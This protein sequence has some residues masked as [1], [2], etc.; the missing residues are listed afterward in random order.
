M[1]IYKQFFE[2]PFIRHTEE[3]Y[4]TEASLFLC[5]NSVTNYLKKVAIR[6]DEE[7]HRIQSYLHVST[8]SILTKTLEDVLIKDQLEVIYME[9]KTLLQ[10]EKHQGKTNS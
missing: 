4:R 6:L 2:E 3:F 9:A 8:L 5:R 1:D 10:E 7:S